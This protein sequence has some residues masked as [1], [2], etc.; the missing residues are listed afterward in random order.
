MWRTLRPRFAAA[1]VAVVATLLWCAPVTAIATSMI[2][3][4][5][6]CAFFTTA[7]LAWLLTEPKH[8]IARHAL[9]AGILTGLAV[10]SKSTAL[11]AVPAVAL[12]YT[13]ALRQEPRRAALAVAIAVAAAG[14]LAAPHFGRLMLETDRSP[15]AVVSGGAASPD[16]RAA[17][18]LQ[19]PGVRHASDYFWFP[20][21]ALLGPI[22]LDPALLRS[23]PGLLYASTW[24]DGHA[25]LLPPAQNP[26][27]LRAE[28]VLAIAG[29]VPTGLALWGLVGIARDR[30]R[31]AQWAGPLAFGAL[32][33]L[34][35]LRYTWTFPQYAA[36][37]ASYFLP[38]MLPVALALA[39]GLEASGRARA[40]LRAFLLAIAAA[41]SALLFYGWWTP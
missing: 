4:E 15:L 2:G 33:T 12:H 41:S 9:V 28:S 26:A 30:E 34:A 29:L 8:G 24:A 37:K 1:D 25:Q 5:M 27:I 11:L 10:L 13:V 19:P 18:A 35:F 23:V 38:A 3:N 31:R 17:M 22:Y 6:V 16:A 32:L 21:A 7:A 14:L 39:V 40:G 36:V 20:S